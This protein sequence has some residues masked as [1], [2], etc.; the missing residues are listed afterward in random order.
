MV[1]FAKSIDDEEAAYFENH[2]AFYKL[3]NTDQCAVFYFEN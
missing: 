2:N 1:E 3:F